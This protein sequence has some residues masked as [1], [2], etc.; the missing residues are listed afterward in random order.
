MNTYIRFIIII[1]VY[2][3]EASGE[4][5]SCGLSISLFLAPLAEVNL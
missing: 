4:I 5:D 2:P 1:L 3:P